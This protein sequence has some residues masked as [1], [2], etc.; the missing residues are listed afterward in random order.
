MRFG[1]LCASVLLTG[2]LA[3]PGAV[4]PA[5]AGLPVPAAARECR[6]SPK[7]L[8]PA[9]CLVPGTM[10]LVMRGGCFGQQPGHRRIAYQP[11]G[12]TLRSFG[13]TRWDDRKIEFAL[14]ADPALKPSSRGL[15]GLVDTSSK[16]PG[17]IG[18]TLSFTVCAGTA[19]AALTGATPPQPKQTAAEHLALPKPGSSLAAQASVPPRR[20]S[21]AMATVRPGGPSALTETTLLQRGGAP[22][23]ILEPEGGWKPVGVGPD[24]SLLLVLEAP[25][26]QSAHN[27]GPSVE[28]FAV[29]TKGGGATAL[30]PRFPLVPGRSTYPLNFPAAVFHDRTGTYRVR[31]S[32]DTGCAAVSPP[33]LL[34]ECDYRVGAVTFADGRDLNE[35]FVYDPLEDIVRADLLVEILWNLVPGCDRTNTVGV[36]SALTGESLVLPS[37]TPAFTSA[38]FDERGRF[39]R[40]V[41]ARPW[42]D[43]LPAMR[44][45]R[46]IPVDIALGVDPP[47]CDGDHSNNSRT[48][49]VRIIT[50]QNNDLTVTIARDPAAPARRIGDQVSRGLL[51]KI[52]NLTWNDAGGPA[53]EVSD[54]EV[55]WRVEVF[56][57]H[58]PDWRT[59]S[60]GRVSFP[61]VR[62]DRWSEARED[63]T[64]GMYEH[65]ERA[66]AVAEIRPRRTRM[67]P[68][69]SNDRAE[70]AD[71]YP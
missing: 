19:G 22:L 67:D 35:G 33:F 59:S 24:N 42:F 40:L 9:G 55:D 5:G 68:N 34:G 20:D 36:S 27:C 15:L 44:R 50:Q 23:R 29:R 2:L 63:V 14:P 26:A 1:N 49:D 11:A 17:W 65:D 57:P 32:T 53:P 52:K 48:V 31:A 6:P 64:F 58:A 41:I 38:D 13:H 45:G 39:V 51:I 10:A 4:H 61:A 43:N 62:S 69:G 47:A 16:P 7:S 70:S 18:R 3:L 71:I 28:F 66:R 30:S 46:F 12:G 54:V 60:G 8:E 21:S 56:N 25:G 37:R